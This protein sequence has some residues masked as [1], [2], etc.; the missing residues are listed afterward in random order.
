MHTRTLPY[1]KNTDTY[2]YNT[3]TYTYTHIYIYIYI[4]IYNIYG[5][6]PVPTFWVLFICTI[7]LHLHWYR[8]GEVPHK[9]HPCPISPI[10][11]DSARSNTIYPTTLKTAKQV[12]TGGGGCIYIYIC[13]LHRYA[14]IHILIY[15]Y[16][17]IYYVHIYIY[18]YIFIFIIY[19]RIHARVYVAVWDQ[20]YC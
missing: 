6:P 14:Y 20:G 2:T 18:I 1:S 7:G 19:S 10:C 3:Y 13:Y 8:G 9:P 17:Q 11:T 16:I 15:T 12:G 5:T 4:Y